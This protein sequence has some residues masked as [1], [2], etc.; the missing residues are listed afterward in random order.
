ML[1]LKETHDGSF[2]L[3]NETLN[4]T[5]HS[6]HGARQEALHVFIKNGLEEV[7]QM[8]LNILEV[9]LGTGLNAMLTFSQTKEKAIHYAALEPFPIDKVI[10]AEIIKCNAINNSETALWNQLAFAE[11]DEIKSIN[12]NSTFCWHQQ[13]LQAFE[14]NE[15]FDLIYFDAFAP[16]KQSEMWD[17]SIFEK[18]YSL[19]N[20]GAILVTYCAQGQFKRN[21]KAA[22][23]T[24]EA[25]PG[26][27]G[28]REM[29]VAYK[30]I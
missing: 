27:P 2:T 19:M 7:N 6:T 18:L 29:T 9:G 23:F 21:L 15:R 17:I 8:P 30:G 1:Q 26:P 10:L 4:E 28:K 24:A 12:N 22:G 25:K 5:Y 20:D 13:T 14:P 3:F 16:N 11:S